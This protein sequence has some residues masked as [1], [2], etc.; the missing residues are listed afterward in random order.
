MTIKTS[1]YSWEGDACRVHE[2]S[3][4]NLTAEIYH[5]GRGFV[6]VKPY[7]VIDNSPQISEEQFYEIIKDDEEEI[8]LTNGQVL[9][10]ADQYDVADLARLQCVDDRLK[11]Y[12]AYH[13][14]K[15]YSLSPRK[16]EELIAEILKD[17]SY[18][19]ELTPATRDGGRDI[20]AYAHTGVTS[21]LMFVECKRYRKDHKVG[22]DVIQRLHG[23]AEIAGAHKTM[24]V[25]TSFFTKPAYSEQRRINKRMEL[26]DYQTLNAWLARYRKY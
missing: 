2:D 16:F 11:E 12:F 5:K 7:N 17:F 10:L 22:I 9:F 26:A 1:F 18:E 15:L 13:P 21:F 23:A 3:M 6:P 24:I 8:G 4:G 19:C 20:Y 25:T 14:E